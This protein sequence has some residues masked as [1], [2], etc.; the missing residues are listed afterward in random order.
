MQITKIV[1]YSANRCKFHNGNRTAWGPIRSVMI[2]VLNKIGRPRSGSPICLITCMI[3]DQI[4]LHE[5]LLPDNHNHY[6]LAN[7]NPLQLPG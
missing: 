3:R 6:N 7:L 1:I 2:R 4:G 5:V